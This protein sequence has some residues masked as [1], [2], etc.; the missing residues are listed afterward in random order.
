MD[1]NLKQITD[2][3]TNHKIGTTVRAKSNITG[4]IFSATVSEA[5]LLGGIVPVVWVNVKHGC[6]LLEDVVAT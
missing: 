2:W 4:Y 3:N 6:R 1:R 5:T